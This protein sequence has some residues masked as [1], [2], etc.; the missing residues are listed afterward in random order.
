[1]KKILVSAVIAMVCSLGAF[2]Q[3]YALIDMEYVLKN[4]PQYEMDGDSCNLNTVS[5]YAIPLASIA[6]LSCVITLVWRRFMIIGLVRKSLA[7]RS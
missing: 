2:A 4:I 1:M 5:H 6:L 3:K 7:P